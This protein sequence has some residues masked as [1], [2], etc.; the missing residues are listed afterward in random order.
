MSVFQTEGEG[1]IPS[2]RTM[3]KYCY[4]NGKIGDISKPQ[5]KLN[6]LGLLRGVGVFDFVKVTSGVPLFWRDHLA[7]F[8][9]SAKTVGLVVPL[10]DDKLTRLAKSLIAKNKLK[11]GSLRLLLT[12][13]ESENGFDKP[14]QPTL[15]I[16]ADEAH[17]L[18]A[19]T[20]KQ[21]GKLITVD[22]QRLWPEAKTT[23]YLLA[24]KLQTA[25]RQAGAVEILYVSRGLVLEAS[26]S[27]L[28]YVKDG[29]IRTPGSGVLAGVTRGMAIKLARKLGYPVTER[30]LSLNELWQADEIFITASNK[31]ILPIV[32]IDDRPIGDGKPGPVTL[33]LLAAYRELVADYTRK[34]RWTKI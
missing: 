29:A 18:P 32:K 31:E 4:A 21:G 23:N 34:F 26:T 10:V 5:I 25:K 9:R 13:G 30:D 3:K 16:L 14:A 12:G 6:D 22:H 27:N 24:I 2:S 11:E 17:L 7:R 33:K 20:W 15:A 8:R 28:F 19:K 1:S